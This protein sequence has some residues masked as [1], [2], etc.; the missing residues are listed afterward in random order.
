ML[1]CI[2]RMTAE[3]SLF[4]SRWWTVA[5]STSAE[6][7]LKL[8]PSESEGANTTPN[9][10][11]WCFLDCSYASFLFPHLVRRRQCT[12]LT[13]IAV[14]RFPAIMEE[15]LTAGVW[16]GDRSRSG[17]FCDRRSCQ[18]KRS[19]P[20]PVVEIVCALGQKKWLC[21]LNLGATKNHTIVSGGIAMHLIAPQKRK[22]EKKRI[23]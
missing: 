7:M 18:H 12:F 17:N 1:V 16:F 5:L 21:I 13:H 8:N 4:A 6:K 9:I 22:K 11:D 15:Q 14:P 20:C 2:P 10:F 23:I 3:N 19:V